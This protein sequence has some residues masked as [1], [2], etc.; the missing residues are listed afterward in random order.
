MGHVSCPVQVVRRIPERGGRGPLSPSHSVPAATAVGVTCGSWHNRAPRS[1]LPQLAKDSAWLVCILANV[2]GTSVRRKSVTLRTQE[3]NPAGAPLR[4]GEGAQLKGKGEG[5]ALSMGDPTSSGAQLKAR[6]KG[7]YTTAEDALQAAGGAG[8]ECHPTH[9]RPG[10][11]RFPPPLQQLLPTSGAG[12]ASTLHPEQGNGRRQLRASAAAVGCGDAR[13]QQGQGRSQRRVQQ[14]VQERRRLRL[15][16]TRAQS[17]A[18]A[19]RWTAAAGQETGPAAARRATP[20]LP[21]TLRAGPA[22]VRAGAQRPPTPPP[23][24]APAPAAAAAA[25]EGHA[26]ARRE[27]A[28][29]PRQPAHRPKWRG[30]RHSHPSLVETPEHG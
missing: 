7:G 8:R 20:P 17:C 28:V 30:Q 14:Q 22:A 26:P 10:R 16:A 13:W 4:G 6:L 3:S 2:V 5:G 18:A 1:I 27:A 12:T 23:A 29:Q 21:T 25:A 19:P 24:A 11:A 9:P 15:R